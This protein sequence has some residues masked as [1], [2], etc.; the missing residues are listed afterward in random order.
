MG[1]FGLFKKKAPAD[2]TVSWLN[3]VDKC[4]TSAMISKNTACLQNYMTRTCLV[5]ISESVRNQEKPY[6]G[7]ERY[8]H[9]NWLLVEDSEARKVYKKL[10]TYD[11]IKMG[12][13]IV[14]AVGDSYSEL[15]EVFV[16]GNQY[17][18]NSIRR[19]AV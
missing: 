11:N 7:I 14:A 17:Q 10:V 16:N 3:D 2:K 9:V 6:S 5:R 18:I 15:W 13:G 19:V 1:L 8:K 12:Q 4:Y